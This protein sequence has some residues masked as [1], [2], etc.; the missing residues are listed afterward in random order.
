V[1]KT[2]YPLAKFNRNF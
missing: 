2:L 1:N